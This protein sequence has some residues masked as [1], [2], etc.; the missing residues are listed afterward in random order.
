MCKTY[1]KITVNNLGRMQVVQSRDDFC[2]VEARAVLRE[3]PFSRQMKKQLPQGQIKNTNT[4]R[5]SVQLLPLIIAKGHVGCWQKQKPIMK[6]KNRYCV[7][8]STNVGNDN[9]TTDENEKRN[10][11]NRW[12]NCSYLTTVYILHHKTETILCLERPLEGLEDIKKKKSVFKT[13]KN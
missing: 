10:R 5:F 4:Y 13:H 9:R 8:L 3:H 6:V 1:L 12:P 11:N 2:S 7:Q